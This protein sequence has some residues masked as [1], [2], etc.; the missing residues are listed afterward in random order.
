MREFEATCTTI[1]D[2]LSNEDLSLIIS[3]LPPRDV[4]SLGNTCKRMNSL[5]SHPYYWK[6][7][8]QAEFPGTDWVGST[9]PNWKAHYVHLKD[10][11]NFL[12]FLIGTSL[13]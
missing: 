1:L 2:I 7:K 4:L 9:F 5:C 3:K 11:D 13:Q 12:I 6:K 10:F 8:I